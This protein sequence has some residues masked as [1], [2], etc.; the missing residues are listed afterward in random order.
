MSVKPLL[1]E[2]WAFLAEL[3]RSSR[4]QSQTGVH[5]LRCSLHQRRA[6]ESLQGFW[7]H[8]EGLAVARAGCAHRWNLRSAA[9]PESLPLLVNGLQRWLWQRGSFY[10]SGA[11]PRL[12]PVADKWLYGSFLRKLCGCA[13]TPVLLDAMTQHPS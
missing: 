2:A 4:R 11:P 13:P 5:G 1:S 8:R 3:V 6:Q 9:P 12:R 7:W 10:T